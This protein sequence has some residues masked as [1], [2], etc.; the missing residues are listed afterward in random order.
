MKISIV[1]YNKTSKSAKA[2]YNYLKN[3]S[4]IP[5]KWNWRHTK[6]V[7][8][9]G[10][11]N[12]FS[13]Y[14]K[15]ILNKPE[16]IK[17]TIN[18]LVF[19]KM[20]KEYGVPIPDFTD[21]YKTALQKHKQWK[22]TVE[23]H[24]LTSSKGR[25]VK[26]IKKDETPTPEAKMWVERIR[27]RREFRFIIVGNK[28]IISMVKKRPRNIKPQPIQNGGSGYKYF[29]T[30]ENEETLYPLEEGWEIAINL[31]QI[32]ELDFGAID[33]MWD[34]VKK[35]WLVLEVNTAFGLGEEN[36]KIVAKAIYNLILEKLKIKE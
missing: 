14:N 8:N 6:V 5:I 24:L 3:V 15:I 21:N 23:R 36:S 31:I 33:I 26:V 34:K 16:K 29:L 25:G 20:C 2:L 9:W 35:R 18:K 28:I 4:I 11:S 27:K 7:I 32:F 19:F 12:H 13:P 17:N 22:G 1:P 30:R 10:K